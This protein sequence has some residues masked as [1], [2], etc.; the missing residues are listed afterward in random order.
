MMN[1]QP[2]HA[3]EIDIDTSPIDEIR[4]CVNIWHKWRGKLKLPIWTG[5]KFLMELPSHLLAFTLIS[6]VEANPLDFKYRYWGSKHTEIYGYDLTGQSCNSIQ[7]KNFA[8]IIFNAH[9]E[10]ANRM[11][12]ILYSGVTTSKSNLTMNEFMLRMPMSIDGKTTSMIIS[13]SW[14]DLSK[15]RKYLNPQE[16]TSLAE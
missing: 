5:S 3:T 7:P 13:I 11:I 15:G 9:K 6:D 16:Y 10:T 2:F 12:P 8:E 4:D 14:T 1:D